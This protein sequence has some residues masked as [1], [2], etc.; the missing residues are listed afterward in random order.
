M[1]AGH[2]VNIKDFWMW[3]V[4]SNENYE[5]AAYVTITEGKSDATY[6]VYVPEG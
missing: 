6:S 4:A 3:V 2:K 5:S 1:P